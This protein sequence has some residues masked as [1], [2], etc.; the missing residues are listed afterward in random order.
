MARLRPHLRPYTT[1]VNEELHCRRDSDPDVF[2]P[3]ESVSSLIV[4]GIDGSGVEVATVGTD[5]MVGLPLFINSEI[6]DFN[7]VTQIPGRGFRM[8][9][10]TLV[11]ELA[12]KG[13]FADHLEE[14][15]E[16][17]LLCI[18]QSCFCSRMHNQLERSA[19]WLL[20]FD[21]RSPHSAFPVTQEFFSQ[22][23]GTRRATVSVA[24]K[25]LKRRKLIVTERRSFRILD[26][27]GLESVACECYRSVRAEYDALKRKWAVP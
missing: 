25:E 22:M 14:Y 20:S 10:R 24:V 4:E 7:A 8:P 27:E 15:T 16:V 11:R 17:L 26:R 3:V 21:D 9:R 12:A 5:G 6:V 23:L 19:R 13:T 1:V 18:G 2:F